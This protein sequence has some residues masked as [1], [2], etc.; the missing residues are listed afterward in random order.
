[1]PKLESV[2]RYPGG[3]SKLANDILSDIQPWMKG[4]F[5]YVEPF[6]G[7]GQMLCAVATRHM[8][9]RIVVNDKDKAVASFWKCLTD[10]RLT[11]LLTGKIESTLRMTNAELL[12]EFNRNYPL[13]NS[14]DTTEAGFAA[15]LRGRTS[16][17]GKMYT[18]GPQGGR[19][20]DEESRLMV[21]AYKPAVMLRRVH[22]LREAIGPVLEVH[23]GDFEAIMKAH[24][25]PGTVI[26]CD[27]PYVDVEDVY[28]HNM[29][30]DADHLRL[31]EAVRRTKRANVAVS[32]NDHPWVSR[33]LYHWADARRY[34]VDYSLAARPGEK[35]EKR[36]ELLLMNR[37]PA[38]R[39]PSTATYW[40]LVAQERAKA[41]AV[42]KKHET[43][44]R[45]VGVA[46][47][48]I[49]DLRLYKTPENPDRTFEEYCNEKRDGGRDYAYKLIR[50]AQA[51]G[52]V[53]R[54]ST[55]KQKPTNEAQ[56]RPLPQ[57]PTPEDQ[58]RAWDIAVA[59]ARKRG[60]MVESPE[61]K[62]AVQ[63]V[64]LEI[65]A[66]GDAKPRRPF[67]FRKPKPIVYRHALNIRDAL[68]TIDIM[69]RDLPELLE[70]RSPLQYDLKDL[71]EY[72]TM[73]HALSEELGDAA[74]KMEEY[75]EILRGVM[76]R[77]PQ[78]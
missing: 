49:R 53:D 76:A 65:A 71:S 24:D 31:A 34:A 57:L 5:V 19:F 9:A 22:A 6:V 44:F 58:A 10:A 21:S 54:L 68:M 23:S 38:A 14:D 48:E 55:S 41:E 77:K 42:V 59:M 70:E 8:P 46:L 28:L 51:A 32:Y 63:Q 36:F 56:V 40:E 29:K 27:P 33:L 61:V 35:R 17:G 26:Y 75:A 74:F 39:K 72:T 50:A 15:L 64:F 52:N 12:R 30:E 2:F 69:S 78:H 11:Q 16:Y 13:L 67:R 4:K 20:Q 66:R 18:G 3:K 1:M 60:K 73:A 47:R 43:M 45:E 37:P 62:E 7:G 25:R